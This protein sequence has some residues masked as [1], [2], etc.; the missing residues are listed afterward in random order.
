MIAIE[1]RV[2]GKLVATCGV[3]GAQNISAI[4]SARRGPK[5]PSG[6]MI[7]T[8][9]CMGVRPKS[10]KTDEV[11]KWVATRIS[12]GDDISFKLVE[13]ASAQEPI[14]KQEISNR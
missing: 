8:L 1:I 10:P 12:L 11:L 6:E 2:N 4:V 9:E 3:E 13:A 5:S 14:D 7:Y